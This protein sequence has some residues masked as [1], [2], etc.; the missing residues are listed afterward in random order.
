M[1]P[2]EWPDTLPLVQS[3]LNNA[4]SLQRAYTAPVSVFTIRDAAHLISTFIRSSKSAPVPVS[5]LQRERASS[6]EQLKT[7]KAELHSVVQDALVSNHW[8]MRE[9][10]SSGSL[11]ECV[12]GDYVIVARQD[13][14]ACEKLLLRWQGAGA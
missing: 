1:R 13:F 12:E 8:R 14:S 4:S 7:W 6:N 9:A 2:E 3:A 11:P 10:G 5:D